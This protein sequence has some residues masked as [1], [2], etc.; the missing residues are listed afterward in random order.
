MNIFIDDRQS[1]INIRDDIYDILEQAVKLAVEMEKLKS[2]V[3]VSIIL[4]DNQQIRELNRDFRG[5]DKETDVLSFPA[6]EYE[7]SDTDEQNWDDMMDQLTEDTNFDSG[8]LILGD[9]AIS[10]EK[11]AQ[12]AE[13]YGHSFYREVA[14][15]AVHGMFHLLG[16]DHENEDDARIMR[17]KEEA[18]LSALGLTRE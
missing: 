12:Q 13:E 11:A 14:F 7:Y 18:V 6:I 9:I 16:Y 8:D 15:L 10:V 1:V 4:I 2:N 5:V 3:E 17:R